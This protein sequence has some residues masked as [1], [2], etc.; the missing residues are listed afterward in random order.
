M[1]CNSLQT[2]LSIA[3]AALPLFPQHIAGNVAAVPFRSD[4]ARSFFTR[5]VSLQFMRLQ[6]CDVKAL[7][8]CQGQEKSKPNLSHCPK[9]RETHHR[10]VI[11]IFCPT[12]AGKLLSCLYHDFVCLL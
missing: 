2:I 7:F 5:G 12:E 3:L 1:D 9:W 4:T 8:C 11:Y 10:N 6:M